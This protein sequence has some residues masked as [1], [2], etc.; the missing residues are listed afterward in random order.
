MYVNKYFWQEKHVCYMC[1]RLPTVLVSYL[2][3]ISSFFQNFCF[4]CFLLKIV[5]NPTKLIGQSISVHRGYHL[6]QPTIHRTSYFPYIDNSLEN[7]S[8]ISFEGQNKKK[9]IPWLESFTRNNKQPKMNR[10]L[11]DVIL[12]EQN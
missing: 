3:E 6:H 4:L 9:Y 1:T 7:G 12:F 11:I 8:C 10:R 2:P 5:L